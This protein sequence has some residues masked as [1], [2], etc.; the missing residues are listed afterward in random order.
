VDEV[1]ITPEGGTVEP[2]MRFF[3]GRAAR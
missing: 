3:K 1:V 2:L